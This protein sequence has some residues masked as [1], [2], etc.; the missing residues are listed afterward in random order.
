MFLSLYSQLDSVILCIVGHPANG[1]DAPAKSS[2]IY[3]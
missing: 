1:E 2:T 3:V